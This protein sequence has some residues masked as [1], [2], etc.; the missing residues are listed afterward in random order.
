SISSLVPELMT[1]SEAKQRAIAFSKAYEEK[2]GEHP[3]MINL[4]GK[5][6]VDTAEAIL[7]NVHTPSDAKAV[8]QFLQS[9]PIPSVQT[10]RFSPTS[11]IGLDES[12]VVIVELKNGQWSKAAP[13]K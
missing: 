12:D 2:Y 7:R 9:H 13:V 1:D 6:N 11:N 3:D 5:L 10:I 8:K 4:L